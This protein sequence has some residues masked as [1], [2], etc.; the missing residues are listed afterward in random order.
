VSTRL[1][2]GLSF[3]AD[4][5]RTTT[6]RLEMVGRLVNLRKARIRA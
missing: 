2:G 3:G 4:L 6:C 1:S 5:S